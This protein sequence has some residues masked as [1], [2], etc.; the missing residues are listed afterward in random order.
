MTSIDSAILWVQSAMFGTIASAVAVI[1]IALVGMAMLGG[2]IDV[3]H[4]IRTVLGCFLIFGAPT[5]AAAFM[6]LVSVPTAPVIESIPV[7]TPLALLPPPPPR[8]ASF[9]PYAGASVPERR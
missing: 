2:R 6:A 7:A 3:R 5:I 1:A 9:D 4:S 8:E